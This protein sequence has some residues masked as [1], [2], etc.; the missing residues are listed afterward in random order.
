MNVDDVL[1]NATRDLQPLHSPIMVVALRGWFDIGEVATGALQRLLREK[2]G[3]VVASI[4]PDPFFD[5][6]Q[7]RPEVW[8]DDGSTRWPVVDSM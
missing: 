6:T 4:D 8:I 2:P 1:T 7:E 5:F 3:P